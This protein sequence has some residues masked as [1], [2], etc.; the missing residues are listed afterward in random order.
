MIYVVKSTGE[1]EPFSEAKVIS[2]MSRAGVP[3]NLQKNAIA[4]I[5]DK[6]Y[7]NI[8]TSKIYSF[9]TE[10]L[11]KDHPEVKAKYNLKQAIMALGPTGYPFEDYV[12]D[13][14]SKFGYSTKTRQILQGRCV[15]HEIDIVA[16]KDTSRIMV[17]AKFHNIPGKK[18]EIHVALYTKARFDDILAKNNLNQVWLI[19]NTKLTTDAI[20]YA[21]CIGMKVTSWDYP[22]GES[23]REL[24]EKAALTPITSL[25]T[26]SLLQQQKLLENHIVL[27]KD[28]YT[29][30]EKLAPLGLSKEQIEKIKQEASF[31]CN[32]S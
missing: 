15:T 16:Q 2:S 23:L 10:F 11:A 8:P 9:I 31:I 6:L 27:C 14:L 25:T 4:Y 5:Q 21:I 24:V 26:F 29:N 13:I 32:L 12:A 20:A 7:Q 22:Q 17:E 30:P 28:I 18:T 19:T 3:Q 1:I